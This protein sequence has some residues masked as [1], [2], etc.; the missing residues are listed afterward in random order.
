MEELN[1]N[2]IPKQ[3]LVSNQNLLP[4]HHFSSNLHTSSN[5]NKNPTQHQHLHPT[6]SVGQ[7]RPNNRVLRHEKIMARTTRTKINEPPLQ[8]TPP[9][10]SEV[11]QNSLR[12]DISDL[13]KVIRPEIT[14]W[15]PNT[16]YLLCNNVSQ[17]IPP[18]DAVTDSPDNPLMVSFLIPPDSFSGESN[19]DSSVLEVT[20]QV[21]DVSTIPLKMNFSILT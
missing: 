3:H 19:S 21:V 14:N 16:S 20:C 11:A 5:Q 15:K 6:S 12:M 13:A 1:Q 18:P 17:I 7:K 8:P 9:Q 4:K 10:T 2:L